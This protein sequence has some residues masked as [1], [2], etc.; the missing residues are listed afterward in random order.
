M[1]CPF[2]CAALLNFLFIYLF[3]S[4]KKLNPKHLTLP[5]MNAKHAT[6]N[7][8]LQPYFGCHQQLLLVFRWCWHVLMLLKKVFCQEK[9]ASYIW[10]CPWH[11][12]ELMNWWLK[13]QRQN[14][15]LLISLLHSKTVKFGKEA[16]SGYLMSKQNRCLQGVSSKN[17]LNFVSILAQ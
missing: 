6:N 16:P 1:F 11:V 2:C 4:Q 8:T 13:C 17:N 14:E 5:N 12:S 9:T 3:S 10:N 7:T 15:I